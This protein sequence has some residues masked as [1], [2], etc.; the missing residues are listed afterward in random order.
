MF[1][2]LCCAY[3]ILQIGKNIFT[4][5]FLFV[6]LYLL[7]SI[8]NEKFKKMKSLL[9]LPQPKAHFAMT[10]F[11]VIP[12]KIDNPI[13]FKLYGKYDALIVS[14]NGLNIRGEKTF[15]VK[16]G[17]ENKWYTKITENELA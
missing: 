6:N 13:P 4:F 7:L 15:G 11:N 8:V 12:I 1:F 14:T 17:P 9:D 2:S 10:G 16:Y 3:V 5:I